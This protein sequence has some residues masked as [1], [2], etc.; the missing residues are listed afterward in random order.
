MPTPPPPGHVHP[1]IVGS[2]VAGACAAV[3]LAESGET[4]YLVIEKGDDVGGT[5]RD[6][7][8]PGAC[9][10]IPSQLYSFSFAPNPDWSRSFSPQPEI[11]AYLERTA[12]ESGVLDGF[13]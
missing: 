7:T 4:D 6:N 8:Y 9:C 12:R 10:D 11:H 2:G 5:W 3:K 1:L 13:R